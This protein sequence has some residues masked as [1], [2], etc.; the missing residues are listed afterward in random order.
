[1]TA[2]ANEDGR[3]GSS[4]AP[5]LMV[6]GWAAEVGGFV[7]GMEPAGLSVLG[8]AEGKGVVVDGV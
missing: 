2:E 4:G 5:V 7:V 6:V 1:M 8:H 3:S